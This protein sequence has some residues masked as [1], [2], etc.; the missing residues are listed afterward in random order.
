VLGFS[1]EYQINASPLAAMTKDFA[2]TAFIFNCGGY[3]CLQAHNEL[4]CVGFPIKFG[5]G[6]WLVG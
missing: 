2:S 1:M 4:A 5:E 6:D 3:C